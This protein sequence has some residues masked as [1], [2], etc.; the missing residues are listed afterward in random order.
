ML[1]A[2]GSFSPSHAIEAPVIP[3]ETVSVPSSSIVSLSTSHA[4]PSHVRFVLFVSVLQSLAQVV[5]VSPESHF[6]L[7]HMYTFALPEEPEPP[8]ELRQ[9]FQSWPL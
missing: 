4:V 7:P 2:R 5:A 6:P 3:K 1:T 9:N 8:P